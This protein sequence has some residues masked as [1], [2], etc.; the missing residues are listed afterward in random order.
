MEAHEDPHADR[1]LYADVEV[2]VLNEAGVGE[3]VDDALAQAGCSWE[4]LQAQA[5]E[6]HF[7]S[8]IA[9][10]VWFVLS[11]F[12]DPAQ[13]ENSNAETVKALRQAEWGKV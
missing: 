9:H 7:V 8:H 5:R 13:V 11:T 2:L 1:D 12:L 4:E 6:G 3:M 10:N